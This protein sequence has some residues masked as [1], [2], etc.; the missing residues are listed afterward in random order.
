[1]YRQVDLHE[2]ADLAGVDA[3][4]LAQELRRLNLGELIEAAPASSREPNSVLSV[5]LPIFNEAE[6]LVSIVDRV[7][8]SLSMLD[9]YEIVV[10]DDGSTDDSVALALDIRRR[11][12]RLKVVQLS[13]NF[14]HQAA[15][16][17]GLT[18]ARGQAVVLMDADGQDPP[19]LLT[20]FLDRW[21]E[22]FDVV[23]GV[24]RNRKEAAWKRAGYAIFYRL[25]Y[26]VAELRMPPDAGDFC[27]MD[28]RVVDAVVSLPEV[29]KF[30]RGLRTWVGYRQVGVEYDRP[31]RVGGKSKYS[32]WGLVKLA[33][34]G[35]LS[36]STLPLRIASLL[37]IATSML[38]ALY[39]ASVVIARLFAGSVPAGWAS[40]IAVVLLLGGAQLLVIGVLGEYL[41]RVFAESKRRPSFI[42]A[43]EYW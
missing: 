3:G 8:R 38:G 33:M 5:V 32:L 37:G 27:L 39:L 29:G 7:Q 43:K 28:R 17:A 36:F 13:R 10:V 19:E 22:G 30:L 42:V 34:D 20:E 24:R 2:A 1:L 21:R 16:T 41:A 12:T 9:S 35:L 15:L 11:D 14:G 31:S 25:L 6:N 40:V 4:D 26:R 18:L 23:Y